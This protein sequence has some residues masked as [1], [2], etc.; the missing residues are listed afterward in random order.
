[1]NSTSIA[2]RI[3][4]DAP[5]GQIPDGRVYKAR[6]KEARDV[7]TLFLLDMSASTDRPIHRAAAR[8]CR[9]A[10]AMTTGARP[11]MSPRS[12]Q[13]PPHHRRQQGGARDCKRR[14]SKRL[15]TPTRSW[16]SRATAGQRRVLR[17]QE[18]DHELGRKLRPASARSSPALDPDGRGDSPH[19]RNSGRGLARQTRLLLVTASAGF[20]LR[21]IAA[22]TPTASGRWSL[23]E[24]EMAGVLPFCITVDRTGHDY[25]RQMCAPSRYCDR[26][27][28]LSRANCPRSTSK[29]SAGNAAADSWERT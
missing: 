3:A 14:R 5:D 11:G 6:K 2:D 7:A 22:R 25:L 17:H 4:R 13:R 12:P 9:G 16:A 21:P 18:F 29:S 1:M 8:A 15:A 24:L 27:H 26:G 19:P 10:G 28:H 23:K 20:R